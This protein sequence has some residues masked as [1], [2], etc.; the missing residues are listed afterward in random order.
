MF[1]PWLKNILGPKAKGGLAKNLHMRFVLMCTPPPLPKALPNI[2][3][4]HGTGEVNIK[5]LMSI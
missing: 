2:Q 5:L 1:G 3:M 4:K